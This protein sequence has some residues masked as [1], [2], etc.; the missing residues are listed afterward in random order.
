MVLSFGDVE[1][2][3]KGLLESL[4]VIKCIFV[5]EGYQDNQEE[6]DK[7]DSALLEGLC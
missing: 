3:V 4:R 7:S 6:E 1:M 2:L 5:A